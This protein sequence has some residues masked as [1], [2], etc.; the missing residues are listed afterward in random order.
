MKYKLLGVNT[1]KGL[2]IGDYIQALASSQFLPQI[3]GFVQREKLSLYS[4]EKCK[5]IMN[6]WYMHNPQ[7]WPPADN[8]D[9]LFVAFH[10]NVLAK[11]NLLEEQSINYFKRHEPIGCRDYETVR[12][13][14]EKGVKAYF[15][16]CMT[17][18]L[19]EKYYNPIK[20][21]KYY[22]VDPIVNR[23]G[24][25]RK[26]FDFSRL[27]INKDFFKVKQLSKIIFQKEKISTSDLLYTFQFYYTY[28]KTIPWEIMTKAEYIVQ[29]YPYHMRE[30]KSDEEF[31][32]EAEALIKKYAKASLVITSR[33]HCALPC[34]G[35]QTPVL[36]IENENQSEASKCRMNGLIELF[37]V[38]KFNKGK[39]SSQ[40]IE[41]PI[42][43][44][45]KYQNKD[46]WRNLAN[47]LTI[48]CKTWINSSN[49]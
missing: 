1:E 9:P 8:I 39:I 49:K 6:G 14:T 43:V 15:S 18:T 27:L 41:L 26:I 42:K 20:N 2:N 12:L 34:L 19:G 40:D 30:G 13:L 29:Q 5:I 48:K 21:N 44:G 31:L 33:I 3:D 35:L 46:T 16:G 32:K 11:R 45:Y 17:L 47:S 37:N 10:L 7:N 38:I 23:G 22:I 28:K 25:K 4:G 36:Y 24:N